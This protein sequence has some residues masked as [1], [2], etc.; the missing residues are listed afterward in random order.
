MDELVKA[1]SS[2]DEVDR[3][4]AAQDMAET[5]NP[6]LAKP[7]ILRLPE[8]ESQAVRDAII[9]GLESLPCAEIYHLIFDLFHSP[10]A[11]LRNAAISIFKSEQGV[12][13]PFL[14]SHLNHA[15]GEVRKLIL[16]AL[17]ATGS[18]K[19][20]SA[21][22]KALDDA[23]VN[24]R[25]TAVEYLGR[26]RDRD[27]VPKLIQGL[28]TEDEPMLR[29]AI[30]ESLLRVGTRDQIMEVFPILVPDDDFSKADLLFMPQLIRL[31]AKTGDAKLIISL[32]DTLTNIEIYAEDIVHA[33]ED[34]SR[35]FGEL[36]ENQNLAERIRRIMSQ[37]ADQE[38]R[39]VCEHLIKQ[40]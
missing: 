7:L 40:T 31:T 11:Y 35:E 22:R 34:A 3:I 33:I 2:P 28:G 15:D 21:I 12:A 8:E 17:F 25:I 14:S 30:L 36:P 16:D 4:Y 27:C 9:F 26:M 5:E 23:S 1:L 6:N 38:L 24:V 13:V 10:D 20:I 37:T 29:M 18:G 39:L 32:I 19:A